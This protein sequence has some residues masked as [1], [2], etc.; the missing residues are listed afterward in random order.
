MLYIKFTL[1]L[2]V[3]YDVRV[4]SGNK[5]NYKMLEIKKNYLYGEWLLVNEKWVTLQ[6]HTIL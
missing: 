4:I 3:I 1:I 2:W 6:P 5:K